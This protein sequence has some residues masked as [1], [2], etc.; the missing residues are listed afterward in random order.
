M[1]FIKS[2][3]LKKTFKTAGGTQAIFSVCL[4]KNLLLACQL[5]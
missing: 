1:K 2:K 4:Q 5:P 3:G